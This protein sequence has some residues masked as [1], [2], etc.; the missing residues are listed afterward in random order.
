MKHN[1]SAQCHTENGSVYM[2]DQSGNGNHAAMVTH[3]DEV[4]EL[5]A[6]HDDEIAE[7]EAQHDDEIAELKAQLAELKADKE[8]LD[9]L[10]SENMIKHSMCIV[11]LSGQWVCDREDIDE[12]MWEDKA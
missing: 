8:R 7:L 2:T 11:D 10:L 9:W 6:Q 3:D 4:A 12:A 5:E 1:T